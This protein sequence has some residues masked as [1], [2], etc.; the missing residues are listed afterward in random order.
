ME[1]CVTK[2]KKKKRKI[3]KPLQGTGGK[4]TSSSSIV[5]SLISGA[6]IWIY[7]I[8]EVFELLEISL[9]L[10]FAGSR[11][12][13]EWP[14]VQFKY[15][16]RVALVARNRLQSHGVLKRLAVIK[17]YNFDHFLLPNFYFLF[18]LITFSFFLFFFLDHEN[19]CTF[20]Y[21]PTKHLFFLANFATHFAPDDL[22]PYS[23]R[24]FAIR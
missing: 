14:F 2:K 16:S 7:V 24:F 6:W 21:F 20:F 19:I 9:K 23:E 15:R 17:S 10:P 13:F 11:V 5:T 1:I 4:V 8:F 3:R 12:Y 18:L 22:N